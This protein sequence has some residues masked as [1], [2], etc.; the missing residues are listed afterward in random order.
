MYDCGGVLAST[1]HVW[2]M[3]THTVTH[4]HW[5]TH[6]ER[7]HH[8]NRMLSFPV[9]DD[10][11]DACVAVQHLCNVPEPYRTSGKE[12]YAQ[13]VLPDAMFAAVQRQSRPLGYGMETQTSGHSRLAAMMR[14]VTPCSQQLR[15]SSCCLLCCL[16]SEVGRMAKQ[17]H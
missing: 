3:L 11:L 1:L 10:F 2:L 8:S 5:Q 15:P 16:S 17:L 9:T 7:L 4:T 12:R 6:R 13:L 14:S